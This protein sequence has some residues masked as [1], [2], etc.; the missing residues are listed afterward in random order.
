MV[1]ECAE[2]L[3]F[4]FFGDFGRVGLERYDIQRLTG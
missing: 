1:M 2:F 3:F 4:Y